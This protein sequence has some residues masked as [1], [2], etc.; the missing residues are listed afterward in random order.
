MNNLHLEIRQQTYSLEQK[1]RR[2]TI[3]MLHGNK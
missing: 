2:L 1:F 3:I